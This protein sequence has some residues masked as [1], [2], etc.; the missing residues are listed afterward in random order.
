MGVRGCRVP[1][2]GQRNLEDYSGK[3]M[4]ARSTW[5]PKLKVERLR[6]LRQVTLCELHFPMALHKIVPVPSVEYPDFQPRYC[7]LTLHESFAHAQARQSYGASLASATLAGID[8]IR[9]R[10]AG[11]TCRKTHGL[12]PGSFKK[13]RAAVARIQACR[14]RGPFY[15][16]QPPPPEAVD[17]DSIRVDLLPAFAAAGVAPISRSGGTGVL[18]DLLFPDNR[19]EQ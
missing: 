10:R 19:S 6:R 14:D 17:R 13:Y 8:V 9:T 16:Q 2:R 12:S 5:Y 3:V 1:C 11:R 4:L 15:G 7:Q 18:T